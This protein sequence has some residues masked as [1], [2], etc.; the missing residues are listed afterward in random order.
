MLGVALHQMR[1]SVG[2]L[3]AASIAIVLGTAFVAATLLVG[4]TMQAT[5]YRAVAAEY[6]DADIVVS[7]TSIDSRTLD[8]A[9][10]EN[11]RSLPGVEAADPHLWATTDV[12]TQSGFAWISLSPPPTHERLSRADLTSG[13]LPSDR[14]QVAV[15][16]DTAATLGLRI[17]DTLPLTWEAYDSSVHEWELVEYPVTVTGLLAPTSG[18]FDARA[19]A[20]V[21]QGTYDAWIEGISADLDDEEYAPE[22]VLVVMQ[23]GVDAGAAITSIEAELDGVT[24]RTVDAIAEERTADFAGDDQ[25]F[26]AVLLG[27]AAISLAVAALVIANTFTVLIAQRTRT[28]ALLR[29]VGASRRQIGRSVLIEAAAMGLIASVAGL[30]FGTALVAVGLRVLSRAN[31]DVPLDTGIHMSL[32][33]VVTTLLVGTLVTILAAS[34]P[35]RLATRVSPLAALHPTEGSPERR[36]GLVRAKLALAGLVIGVLLLAGGIALA[37]GGAGE[38]DLLLIALALGILGGL[39]T[40]GALLIGAVFVVPPAI[41]LLGRALG[42]NSTAVIATANAVRNPKRTAAT[43]SA[44]V[45][46]VTLV[47]LM[48]TGALTA[49]QTLV[50]ELGNR[51]AVDLTVSKDPTTGPLPE[52]RIGV[53]RQHPKV[54]AVV[55]M[56][57]ALVWNGDG[58]SLTLTS[59]AEGDLESVVR[60]SDIP[61]WLTP[62]TVLVSPAEAA[63]SG[64]DDGD[65]FTLTNA[66]LEVTLD[67]R[68]AP[69]TESYQ[70]VLAHPDVVDQL[71]LQPSVTSAWARLADDANVAQA[72]QEIQASLDEA[73]ADEPQG[74]DSTSAWL[75]G[76]A[77]ERA[78]YE[79]VIN[80]LLAIVIGLLA[81]SVVIALVGVANT[82]SLSVIERR[83]ES[84]MLRA[85]GLSK[86]QL[87][88]MLAIEG[89]LIA[90]AGAVIGI[91]AGLGFGWA[92][93]TIVLGGFGEVVLAVPWRD[94]VIVL[95]IAMIA[96]LLA[97]VLPAR[98]A[99][100]TS[101][102]AALAAD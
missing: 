97:S 89:V 43:A 61:A 98:S 58:D 45:I 26:T 96:G 70:E 82:L 71:G 17:G 32:G 85:V 9:A 56:N 7:A 86:R 10:I 33:I 34:V 23:S 55:T 91:V 31:L 48:S 62:S 24:A 36:S 16:S 39:V 77:I 30:G 75:S 8:R 51:L 81:I 76:S 37:V 42:R 73:Q 54:D 100:R 95:A 19:E 93:S 66:D 99:V 18:F 41:R 92:G 87:R 11:L 29:C 5:T 67:V 12:S 72:T 4:A 27:F 78:A 14:A 59:V 47:T 2:R 6:A 13:Q 68:I 15:N 40:L 79:S 44:L 50:Q 69:L 60:N 1:A 3:A 80:T 57:Q 38:G 83:R 64:L 102:V 63:M 22:Q 52:D 46:G 28:L 74:G 101:P 94:L 88:G 35:A 84:A 65:S 20:I 25:I 53:L 90:L 21:D 49:R